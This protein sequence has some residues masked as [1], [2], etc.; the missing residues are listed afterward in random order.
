LRIILLLLESGCSFEVRD[1]EY[2][3]PLDLLSLI[4]PMNPD[5]SKQGNHLYTWGSNSNYVLGHIDGVDRTSPERVESFLKGKKIDVIDVVI[6]KFHTVI[7][8][9]GGVVYTCGFGR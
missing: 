7:L 2:N 8:T 9:S 4:I 3:S 5:F 1:R 6:C